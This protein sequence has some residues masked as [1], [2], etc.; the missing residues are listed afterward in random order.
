MTGPSRA[1]DGEPAP[2]QGISRSDVTGGVFQ[3]NDVGGNVHISTHMPGRTQTPR[4]GRWGFL[5]N[6][7]FLGIALAGLAAI[8][9]PSAFY[10]RGKV[11]AGPSGTSVRAA[12][13]GVVDMLVDTPEDKGPPVSLD[14]KVLNTGTQRS[15]IKRAVVSIRELSMLTV[16]AGQS[17]GGLD[18]S[19]TYGLT[20]PVH[21]TPGQKVEI[22]L[23]QEIGPDEADRFKVGMRLPK[24][25]MLIGNPDADKLFIYRID[26]ELIRDK[27]SKVVSAGEAVV[28]PHGAVYA[29]GQEFFLTGDFCAA[30]LAF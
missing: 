14:I 24:T 1:P 16:C 21:P 13:I 8:A 10:V 22:P 20:L 29:Q 25:A 27:N 28:V 5:A 19:A 18:V 30:L 6:P 3:V 2:G 15:I 9:I 12:K 11:A 4:R 17:G 23:S 26:V 7:T